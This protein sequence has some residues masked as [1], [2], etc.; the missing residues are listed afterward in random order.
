MCGIA[1][2]IDWSTNIKHQQ[3]SLEAMAAPMTCRGPDGSGT[4]VS[5][6]AGLA[7]RRLVVID[8]EGGMQPMSRREGDTVYTIV[9]NGE[10][11][12]FQDLRDELSLKGYQFRS[13]SDTEVLLTSYIEWGEDSVN[14]FNGIFAFAIWNSHDQS[15]FLARDRLGVKPLFYAR[16]GHAFLFASEIKG[17]LAHPL[18]K[19]EVDRDGLAEI[20]A[21]GPSRTPGH[22]VFRGIEELRPGH[23]L[24][25]SH[26]GTR[27]SAY[28][29]L[30]S[31]PHEDDVKTTAATIRDLLEDAITRQLVSDVPVMTLLSGGL[32]SSLVTAVAAKAFRQQERGPLETFSIDFVDIAKYFEDNGF[33]TNMDAPWVKVVS[34]YLGTEHHRVV[35]D[36]PDLDRNLEDAMRARDLPGHADVDISL[37]VFARHIKERATVGLS[38]EA[39]DEIFGGYPWF[40][41]SDALEAET[42]PWSL[43]LPDRLSILETGFRDSIGAEQ[44]VRDRYH[45]ALAEVPRLAG[46]SLNEARI[47]EISYL[48]ITRFLPTLLDRKDRMTMAASLEVRVPFCDHRLVEYVWNIP[49]HMKTYGNQAKGILREAVTGWLP[50]EVRLRR[51]SPY[52]STPNPTYFRAMARRM[53]A[54]LDDPTSPLTPLLNR[55]SIQAV[56]EAGPNA[57]QIP[58]FGQLMGNA[59]LFAYLAQVDAWFKEYQVRIV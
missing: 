4:W 14:H 16:R 28:W 7:H 25:Y 57:Q 35:L 56:V 11:Y 17:L 38:G 52:P 34:D 47:R 55:R 27:V 41:R 44:Y 30:H 3:R 54:I 12:N 20:F 58:W 51:K 19:P 6:E 29:R 9:Y 59:Q 13:R 15:L 50:E 23:H 46:E 5:P 36:T 31:E 26:K 43:R 45:E 22:G 8:P 21:L 40:H 39:A 2:W 53:Q 1:G 32:D 49:W 18:V 24:T 42:F 48:S 10:L 33:Q 37:L